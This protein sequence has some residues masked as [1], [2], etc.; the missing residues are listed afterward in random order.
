VKIFASKSRPKSTPSM[1]LSR[2]HVFVGFGAVSGG[3]D[4]T[5]YGSFM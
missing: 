2:R 4:T 3:D 5:G 1:I